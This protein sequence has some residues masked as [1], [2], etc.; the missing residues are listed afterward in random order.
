MND[1]EP[2]CEEKS[3]DYA[4]EQQCRSAR[5]KLQ[6]PRPRVG[7]GEPGLRCKHTCGKSTVQLPELPA[8]DKRKYGSVGAIVMDTLAAPGRSASSLNASLK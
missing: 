6:S 2:L 1:S 8:A 3:V 7:Q 4:R 5:H